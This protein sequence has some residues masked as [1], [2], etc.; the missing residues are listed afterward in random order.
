M[1]RR[2]F[3][4]SLELHEAM[5]RQAGRC[6]SRG[7]Q[8]RASI[9]TSPP[10][11]QPWRPAVASRLPTLKALKGLKTSQKG[12]DSCVF[13]AFSLRFRMKLLLQAAKKPGQRRQKQL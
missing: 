7:V 9:R 1:I 2:Q 3:L 13:A 11:R 4:Y 10:S 5:K 8:L 12:V 6:G